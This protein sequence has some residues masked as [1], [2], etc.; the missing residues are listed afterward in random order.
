MANRK[1]VIDRLVLKGI[2]PGQKH[3]LTGGLAHEL[4]RVL[5]RSEDPVRPGSRSVLKAGRVMAKPGMSP[6][7][8]GTLVA[9]QVAKK[10]KQ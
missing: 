7:Q 10:L 1:I 2:K 4:S 6:R 9:R 3:L 8:I 5:A